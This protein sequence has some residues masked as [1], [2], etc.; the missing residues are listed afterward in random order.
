LTYFTNALFKEKISIGNSMLTFLHA[1]NIHLDSP[2]RGLS[3]GYRNDIFSPAG[4]DFA[5]LNLLI[6][7]NTA[8]GGQASTIAQ[9][10]YR[11]LDTETNI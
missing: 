5:T 6:C 9:F 11:R 7:G 2:L 1:A 10:K 4:R 3:G 8:K